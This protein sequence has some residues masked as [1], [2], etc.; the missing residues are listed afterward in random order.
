MSAVAC[1]F[2]IHARVI[3]SDGGAPILDLND[4]ANGYVMLNPIVRPRANPRRART[5]WGRAHG[6]FPHGSPL[7]SAGVLIVNGRVEGTSWGQVQ[8][9]WET[10]FSDEEASPGH[11]FA[12]WDYFVELVEE[13]VTRR[14]RTDWP[15]VEP[16]ATESAD[17]GRLWMPYQ[18]RWTVQPRPLVTIGP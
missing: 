7:H 11:V 17:I 8:E 16:I 15:S 1:D 10:A 6:D 4:Q 3:P 14:W 9:R 5:E 18:I 2:D 13:G 12:E